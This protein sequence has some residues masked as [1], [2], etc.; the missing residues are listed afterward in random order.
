MSNAK[1]KK[2]R[3]HIGIAFCKTCKN[4]IF[5]SGGGRYKGCP[6]GNSFIDQERWDGRYVR[7]GG[8]AEFIEQICPNTCKIKE[9]RKRDAKE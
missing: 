7:I 6:C 1:S 2:Y 4:V 9:H 5:S 3:T 8:E